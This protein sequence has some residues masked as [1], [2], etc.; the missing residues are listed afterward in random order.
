MLQ[1]KNWFCSEW[2]YYILLS[3]I[4]LLGKALFRFLGEMIPK[5]K[6]RQSKTGQSDSSG[7]QYGGASSK[8]KKGTKGK[9]KWTK[10]NNNDNIV[11][12]HKPKLLWINP[13]C[14]VIGASEYKWMRNNAIPCKLQVMFSGNNNYCLRKEN[15][16]KITTVAISVFCPSTCS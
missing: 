9:R 5:L 16:W 3:T 12:F 1:D 15:N 14:I 6:S 10:N 4:F 8:K 13:P 2:A 11:L 7:Q